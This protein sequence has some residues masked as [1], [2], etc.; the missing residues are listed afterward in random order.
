MAAYELSAARRSL[1]NHVFAQ[2]ITPAELAGRRDELHHVGAYSRRARHPTN[3]QRAEREVPD[4]QQHEQRHGAGEIAGRF[5]RHIA[6]HHEVIGRR[7]HHGDVV[8]RLRGNADQV[9][10][11]EGRIFDD[12]LRGRDPPRTCPV[13]PARSACR[14]LMPLPLPPR[15]DSYEILLHAFPV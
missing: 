14:C 15:D 13:R 10:D 7:A 6:V 8:G 12:G 5:E 9:Q 11:G 2:R 1:E 4:S 3:Q